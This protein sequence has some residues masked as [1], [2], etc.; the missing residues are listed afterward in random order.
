MIDPRESDVSEKDLV[1]F[2]LLGD[3]YRVEA[4]AERNPARGALLARISAEIEALVLS[5]EECNDA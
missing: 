2:R 1:A 4:E 5:L 3:R